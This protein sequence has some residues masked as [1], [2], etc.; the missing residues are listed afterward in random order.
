MEAHLTVSSISMTW[1]IP[2]LPLTLET[3]L[4]LMLTMNTVTER[5]F[6][7][8]S[9]TLHH[10][11]ILLTSSTPASTCLSF[12][13]VSHPSSLSCLL[14]NSLCFWFLTAW[15]ISRPCLGL[16]SL[17]P[18]LLLFLPGSKSS[19]QSPPTEPRSYRASAHGA[20]CKV[21]QM[22]VGRS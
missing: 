12:R 22:L 8:V 19:S 11:H 5:M 20:H 10:P 3:V 4:D 21:C 17:Q 15:I 2:A 18:C 6:F 14:T 7:T 9:K 16:R 13:D 1:M